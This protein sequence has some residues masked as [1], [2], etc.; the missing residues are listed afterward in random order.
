ME[1]VSVE[2]YAKLKNISS[3]AVYKQI[4]QGKLES[5][6]DNKNRTVVEIDSEQF[7]QQTHQVS[8]E[9]SKDQQNNQ[10]D[11]LKEFLGGL[12]TELKISKDNE[13]RRLIESHD[14]MDSMKDEEIERLRIEIDKLKEKGFFKK[15]FGG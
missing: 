7:N 15:L 3:T 13:I 14:K 2:A 9:S 8:I 10:F 12:I 11:S 6:K 5:K 1:W 4:K